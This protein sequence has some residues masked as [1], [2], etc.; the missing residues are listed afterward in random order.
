MNVCERLEVFAAMKVWLV[1]VC[2]IMPYS[3]VDSYQCF[4]GTY[5]FHIKGRIRCCFGETL[6]LHLW[7]GSEGCYE[8]LGVKLLR[9][10]C[11]H[12]QDNMAS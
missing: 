8:D 4:E 9:N 3:I 6:L 12:L 11:I 5:D 2:I 7:G 10:G 1:V